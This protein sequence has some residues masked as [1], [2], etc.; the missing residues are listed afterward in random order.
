[1]FA[2]T[3][4][5]TIMASELITSERKTPKNVTKCSRIGVAQTNVPEVHTGGE[6]DR[7]GGGGGG[8]WTG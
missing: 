8:R 1:M 2:N 4:S 6:G 7:S 3:A 5:M